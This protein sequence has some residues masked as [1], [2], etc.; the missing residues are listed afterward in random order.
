MIQKLNQHEVFKRLCAA[1]GKHG[2]YVSWSET[3]FFGETIKAAPY[4]DRDIVFDGQ[5]VI[6]CDTKEERDN[7]YDQTVGDDGP[8]EM[9]SYNGPARVYVLT[10]D[11]HGN[12]LT[13]NT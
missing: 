12:L 2:L 7:L 1:T 9:N 8:T 13:E 6:L 10:C 5:C 11:S 4:L 3:H